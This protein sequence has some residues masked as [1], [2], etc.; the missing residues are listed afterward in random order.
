MNPLDVPDETY[1]RNPRDLAQAVRRS[2]ERT[3][4]PPVQSFSTTDTFLESPPESSKALSA[5]ERA[6]LASA[7]NIRRSAGVPTGKRKGGP[8]KRR[9]TPKK[10]RKP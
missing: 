7:A 8:G 6:K 1:G 4:L 10:S 2:T 3:D 9:P 5:V